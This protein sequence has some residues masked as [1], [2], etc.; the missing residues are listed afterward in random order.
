MEMTYAK[1]FRKKQEEEEEEE[2]E[3]KEDYFGGGKFNIQYFKRKMVASELSLKFYG[4]CGST[5]Q[6]DLNW[7]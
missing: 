3:E 1:E 5:S 6:S 2:E 7:I 4:N